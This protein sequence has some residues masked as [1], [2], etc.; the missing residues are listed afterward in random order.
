V[1][2]IPHD[3]H[4]TVTAVIRLRL[5][6]LGQQH[7]SCRVSTDLVQHICAALTTADYCRPESAFVNGTGTGGANDECGGYV[8]LASNLP[9]SGIATALNSIVSYLHTAQLCRGVNDRHVFVGNAAFRFH[10]SAT[11]SSASTHCSPF[12]STTFYS[13]GNGARSLV[14]TQLN[15]QC[16]LDLDLA[17]GDMSK[18]SAFEPSLHHYECTDFRPPRP[19]A[20]QFPTRCKSC[21]DLRN[22]V[23]A[24]CARNTRTAVHTTG[25][26]QL[27]VADDMSIKVTASPDAGIAMQL[28][29][30]SEAA[31]EVQVRTVCSVAHTRSSTAT[32]RAIHIV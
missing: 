5:F 30:E 1:S 24:A 26:R 32:I 9:V 13:H 3:S 29:T 19:V 17:A 16:A 14:R 7:L 10:N 15:M 12:T 8:D 18:V 20:S 11:P 6:R 22:A 21:A 28:E 31:I 27:C 4:G 23:N 25:T 2:W